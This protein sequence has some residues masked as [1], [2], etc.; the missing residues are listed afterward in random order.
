ML[1]KKY[2]LCIA[3]IMTLEGRELAI[4]LIANGIAAHTIYRE[5]KS[6]PDETTVYDFILKSV[7]ENLRVHITAELI[8]EVYVGVTKAHSS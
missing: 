8:D 5:N 7:P 2:P 3:L 4:A 1:K 6:I